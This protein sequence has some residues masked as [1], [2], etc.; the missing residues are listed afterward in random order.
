MQSLF[1]LA[2]EANAGAAIAILLIFLVL[3]VI[4]L[5]LF[6]FWIWMLIDCCTKEPK[7]KVMWILLLVFLGWIG[8]IAYFFGGRPKPAKARRGSRGGS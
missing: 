8:A 1:L 5:A 6:G 2:Q 7:N 3:L 4:G